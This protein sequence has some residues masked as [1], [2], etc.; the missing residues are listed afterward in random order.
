[1]RN[2]EEAVAGG[3]RIREQQERK[4]RKER[5]MQS[6]KQRRKTRVTCIEKGKRGQWSERNGGGSNM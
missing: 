2:E 6:E 5:E 1:M 3:A 4:G